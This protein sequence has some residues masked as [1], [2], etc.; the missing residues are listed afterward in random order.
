MLPILVGLLLEGLMDEKDRGVG[1]DGIAAGETV[2]GDNTVPLAHNLC[3]VKRQVLVVIVE[4][5]LVLVQ[6]VPDLLDLGDVLGRGDGSEASAAGEPRAVVEAV[7]ADTLVTTSPSRGAGEVIDN[8]G[9][10]LL[11]E[12]R[13]DKVRGDQAP[14]ADI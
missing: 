10:V 12:N 11:P 2:V 6:Q 14:P 3:Y 1:H 8:V 9:E 4:R 7:F 13:T 5:D